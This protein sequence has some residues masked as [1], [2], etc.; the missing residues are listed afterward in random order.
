MKKEIH[1]KYGDVIY[2]DAQSGDQWFSR[3]TK[4]DGPIEVVD[5]KEYRV[6]PL[7]ISSYT[8]PFYSGKK[9]FVDAAG[10]VEKFNK[11]FGRASMMSSKKAKAGTPKAAEAE[12][13]DSTE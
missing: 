5:G 2:R 13:A 10:R 6:I 3:S 4:L 12:T 9:T 1:P 7:E 8:H 11:R